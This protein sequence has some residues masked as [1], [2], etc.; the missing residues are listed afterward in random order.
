VFFLRSR[1]IGE[2]QARAMLTFAF[3][4]EILEKMDLEPVRSRLSE[5]LRQRL[6]H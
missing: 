6:P 4:R 5:E 2:S 3:A 1:G